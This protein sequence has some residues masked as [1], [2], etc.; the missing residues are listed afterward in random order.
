MNKMIVNMIFRKIKALIILLHLRNIQFNDSFH[1][2]MILLSSTFSSECATLFGFVIFPLMHYSS[3]L[4][5]VLILFYLCGSNANV[6][7]HYTAVTADFPLCGTIR[8]YY[9]LFY[10]IIFE[11]TQVSH[12]SSLN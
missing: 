12:L 1:F 9:F 2:K 4:I 11:A 8:D 10:S 6:T 5:S 7:C 3:F